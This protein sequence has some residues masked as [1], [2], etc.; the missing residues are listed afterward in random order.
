MGISARVSREFTVEFCFFLD[1]NRVAYTRTVPL[2]SVTT[3]NPQ[4]SN[5]AKKKKRL[6]A[7]GW[8]VVPD[9]LQ[10]DDVGGR[11]LANIARGIYNHEAVLREYVQ[12]A[13]DAYTM[14]NIEDG[15]PT[16]TITAEGSNVSIQDFGIGMDEDHIRSVKKVAVSNKDDFQDLAGFRGIGIWAGLQA[17][18]QLIIVTTKK[19]TAKKYRL[20]IDF[21][22]ITE[23]F[24]DNINIKELIDPNYKIEATGA[25]KE[26]HYTRTTLVGV[27]PGYEKLLDINELKRIAST[28]LP[29][30]IDPT[31]PHAAKVQ[32]ILDGISYYRDY[33]IKV[34]SEEVFRR[35]PAQTVNSPVE[36][37][38][39]TSAGIEVGRVWYCSTKE[40][41]LDPSG[42]QLRVRNIA[43]GAPNIYGTEK[44][45]SYNIFGGVEL[46]ALPRL[47][48]F[49]GEIHV[50]NANIRPN[51]PRNDIELDAI[52]KEFIESVRGFY[53]DRI[54]EAG[55]RSEYNGFLRALK[56][57]EALLD[58]E[59]LEAGTAEARDAQQWLEKLEKAANKL[60]GTASTEKDR[61]L[62]RLLKR[63]DFVEKR[64]A[65][66]NK[67]RRIVP[68]A[69]GKSRRGKKKS[70]PSLAIGESLDQSKE[71]LISAI[72][73][74]LENKIGIDHEEFQSLSIEINELISNWTPANA[75]EQVS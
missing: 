74:L 44:A 43:V 17:C 49:F 12:N 16:I 45:D 42:F 25:P 52:S 69:R 13:S 31:F 3:D 71:R 9:R 5:M 32:E 2:H 68:K 24:D 51:T 36:L 38:L 30:R 26:E 33:V 66:V 46:S 57:T 63:P 21:A 29:C 72:I 39:N 40:A 55:G 14:M 20:E 54:S 47:D 35:R 7:E 61:V 48:W 70:P 75:A 50:T 28:I 10:W 1:F 67:L 8:T 64:K 65:A 6:P 11:L 53:F 22:N 41:S 27:L 15:D 56:K 59:R 34:G 37:V 23:R 60:K 58:T 18:K 73:Q 62:R 4:L 19:G